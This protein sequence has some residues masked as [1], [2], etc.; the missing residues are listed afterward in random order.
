MPSSLNRGDVNA[1]PAVCNHHHVSCHFTPGLEHHANPEICYP[2]CQQGANR[3]GIVR[4]LN[5]R[6]TKV[7]VI[8]AVTII[9]LVESVSDHST[10]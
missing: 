1:C 10:A 2:G 6:S 7:S 8:H 3:L 9:Q 4:I 5:G